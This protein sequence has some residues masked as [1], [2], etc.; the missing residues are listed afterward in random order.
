MLL[1]LLFREK[2]G[3][4]EKD[5]EWRGLVRNAKAEAEAAEEVEVEEETDTEGEDE[6][7][8]DVNQ[9]EEEG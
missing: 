4:D 2:D 3:E 9:R 1:L 7:E 6:G 8:R 5:E